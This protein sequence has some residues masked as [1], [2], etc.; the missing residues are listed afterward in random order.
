VTGT[1]TVTT[2]QQGAGVVAIA[3]TA[4]KSL[5]THYYRSALR[6]APDAGGKTYWEGEA[7]RVFGLGANVNEAWYALAMS[8]YNS[9]EYTAFGRNDA[10]YLTDLYSTFFNRAPDTAGFDYWSGLLASGLPR[11]GAL[12]SFM[13]STE[14][15]N[16]TQGVFGN[17][18]ARA[19]VDA[20]VDFY[21]GLLA[22]LPDS[23]GY[24]FWLQR[25]RAAQCQGASAVRAE[26]ETISNGFAN[27]AEYTARNRSTAQYVS[28][29]YNAFLRRGPDLAGAQY[30]INQINTGA[31]SRDAV[32]REF[33]A[34]PEFTNRV[35]AI[36]AQG[37]I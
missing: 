35:N 6:R 36:I 19:E 27:G 26:A 21:R 14:F 1:L 34:S 15:A 16:F 11:E 5:V 33:T 28:D 17:T 22:R 31:R 13:F 32:R 37:C 10:G 12:A 29:L 20:V 7:A 30:W 24:N 4:E 2:V 8:F 23:A 9:A 25:F 3:G 18:A